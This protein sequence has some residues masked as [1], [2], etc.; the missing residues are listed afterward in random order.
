M[1]CEFE[2]S[3]DWKPILRKF[4]PRFCLRKVFVAPG[5]AK[6]VGFAQLNLSGRDMYSL[7]VQQIQLLH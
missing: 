3:L 1:H 7:N 4:D 2:L 5:V 6:K